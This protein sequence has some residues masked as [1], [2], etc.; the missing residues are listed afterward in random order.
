[1]VMYKAKPHSGIGR[2]HKENM[3]AGQETRHFS[4]F[5]RERE[6]PESSRVST[7]GNVLYGL[8]MVGER[9]LADSSKH[10]KQN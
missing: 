10:K 9:M 6:R 2:R 5:V 1:M 7:V 3:C 8:V 4:V